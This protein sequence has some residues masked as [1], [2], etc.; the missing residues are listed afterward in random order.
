MENSKKRARHRRRRNGD[1]KGVEAGGGIWGDVSPS[2]ADY[3]SPGSV[4]S[5]PSGCLNGN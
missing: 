5:S 3:R 4:V 2:A 1:A